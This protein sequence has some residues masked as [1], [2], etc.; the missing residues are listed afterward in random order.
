MKNKFILAA[1]CIAFLI[2]L[3][4]IPIKFSIRN[5]DNHTVFINE[6]KLGE[7][8]WAEVKY[9]NNKFDYDYMAGYIMTGNSPDK[10]L[11]K[12]DFDKVKLFLMSADNKNKFLIYYDERILM[13]DNETFPIYKIESKSWDILY[14]VHRASF[15]RLYAPKSYLTIYDF[16]WINVIKELLS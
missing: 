12:R 15:R 7:T 2:S 8:E 14:P 16:N 6:P 13:K 10:R 3:D 5:N 9:E 1:V 4:F 11:N